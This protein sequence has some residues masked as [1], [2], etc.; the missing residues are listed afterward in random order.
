MPEI[1]RYPGPATGRTKTSAYGD[2]VYTVWVSPDPDADITEQTRRTLDAIQDNLVE[3]GSDKTRLLSVTVYITDM[4]NKPAMDVVWNEWI[5]G[6]TEHWPQRACV[7]V[8]LAA[9]TLVE[10]VAVGVRG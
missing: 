5:G 8:G 2:L 10:V 3:A 1:E 6:D 4:A 7:Q 9:D